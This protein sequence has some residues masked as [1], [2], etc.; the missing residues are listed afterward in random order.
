MSLRDE[1]EEDDD[2]EEDNLVVGPGWIHFDSFSALC[3]SAV[4]V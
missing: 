3:R 1:D 2:E 4:E